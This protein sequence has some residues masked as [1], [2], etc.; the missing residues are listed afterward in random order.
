MKVY[1]KRNAPAAHGE[2]VYYFRGCRCALCRKANALYNQEQR[3]RR[4]KSYVRNCNLKQ[5]HGMTLEAYQK[6]HV[7]R[8]GLCDA[9]GEPETQRNQYGPVPL[10]V[11][12]D[13]KTG[14]IRGLLCMKCNRT[15]GLVKES[16]ATLGGLISYLEVYG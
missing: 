7:E 5:S 9:C 10:A 4:G 6:M 12:H 3:A 8:E 1:R 2:L 13:H 16:I 15:L 11:D 14:R